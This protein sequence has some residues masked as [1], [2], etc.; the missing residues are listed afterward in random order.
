MGRWL[1]RIL[2]AAFLLFV[3][4]PALVIAIYRVVPPLYTPLMGL[5]ALEGAGVERQWRP[6]HEIS[7][8]LLRAIIASED[9][10]FCEHRGFDWPAMRQEWA[11]YR[12]GEP[13]RGASTITMQTAKNLLLWPGRS[14]VRKG[15]EAWL[16][17]LIEALWDKQRILEVY[18][19]IVE[20]AP[21]VYGA[22]AAAQH[23][24]RH[25]ASR[26]TTREAA[27]LAAVLP[28]PRR[29]SASRPTAYIEQRVATIQAR[30]GSVRPGRDGVCG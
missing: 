21:G 8:A 14:L 4:A 7:P 29:W 26:L 2:I 24:F 1:K 13:S 6:I 3:L 18:A 25:P 15:L 20:W 17:L 16:T 10:R 12:A 19:N 23:H 9:A 30:A 5:R 11:L 22:E 27:L 28:N